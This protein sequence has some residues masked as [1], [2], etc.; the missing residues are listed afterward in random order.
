MDNIILALTATLGST[1]FSLLSYA[2]STYFSFFLTFRMEELRLT[3]LF[4]DYNILR[5]RGGLGGLGM[6]FLLYLTFKNERTVTN[7]RFIQLLRLRKYN[8]L[9]YLSKTQLWFLF[10]CLSTHFTKVSFARTATAVVCHLRYIVL[11]LTK[12][13]HHLAQR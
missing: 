12:S 8:K 3:L 7:I 6:L 10:L 1:G 2:L 5:Y 9:L 11:L 4:L 13:T